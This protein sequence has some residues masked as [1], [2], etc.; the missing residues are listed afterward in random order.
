SREFGKNRESFLRSFVR[1]QLDKIDYVEN[2]RIVKLDTPQL[3]DKKEQETI[4]P[5]NWGIQRIGAENAWSVGVGGQDILIAVIDSGIDI[6]HPLLKNQIYH[7]PGEQGLDDEGRS[8]DDNG[9]DDDANGLIDDV[10]GYDFALDTGKIEDHSFHGTHIAGIIAAEHHDSEHLEGHMQGTAP[11]AKLLPLTFIDSSGAGALG[12]AIHAID[13]AVLMGAKIINASWG[14]APCSK[15][16][17]EKIRSL[18]QQ[19]I[20]FVSAAGNR[21]SN[22]DVQKEYPASYGVESQITVGAVGP[23]DLMAD[24]SNYGD[25]SVHLFAPGQRIVSTIPGGGLQAASGTSMAAPFVAGA[26]ALLWSSRPQASSLEIRSLLLASIHP[27]TS[28]RNSTQGRLYLDREK[29]TTH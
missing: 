28:Y 4:R 16:L 3:D 20:L 27:D 18:I 8:K 6:H 15:I 12:D 10:T 14:G 26:A 2:D 7:N 21:G 29:F 11:L 19:N 9:I 13:Y 17:K 24:Y 22:I 1:P 5:D 25:L 23:L